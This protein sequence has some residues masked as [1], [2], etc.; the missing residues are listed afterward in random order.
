VYCKAGAAEDN[1]LGAGK[2]AIPCPVAV[3]GHRV[4]NRSRPVSC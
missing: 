2:V 4:T 1:P 3:P